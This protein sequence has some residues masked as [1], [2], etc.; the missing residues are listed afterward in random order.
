MPSH[1]CSGR[2][3]YT[4]QGG[5]TIGKSIGFNE[6]GAYL[7]Y[8]HAFGGLLLSGQCVEPTTLV[9][10]ER[11]VVLPKRGITLGKTNLCYE[12]LVYLYM[13]SYGQKTRVRDQWATIQSWKRHPGWSTADAVRHLGIARPKLLTWKRKY[14]DML[15][16]PEEDGQRYRV[17]GAGRPYKLASY[18]F[19]ALEYYDRSLREDEVV[20]YADFLRYLRTIPE[21]AIIHKET[22][23]SR[24]RR[25]M[26]RYDPGSEEAGATRAAVNAGD[27][28]LHVE[29]ELML[30]ARSAVFFAISYAYIRHSGRE[31]S[32]PDTIGDFDWSGYKYVL[33]PVAF[34]DHWSVVFIQNGSDAKKIYYH[35]DSLHNGHDKEYIFACLDWW[36]AVLHT[37]RGRFEAARGFSHTCKPRQ[38]NAVDC[39]I[40]MLH[41]LY[42]VAQHIKQHKPSS[43]LLQI[44]T[45]AKGGFNASK[46]NQART[47]LLS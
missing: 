29:A 39:G 4:A 20:H 45:L 17:K 37:S 33:L 43:I 13:L 2:S 1:V 26:K 41:Y 23:R 28:A 6:S 21:F 5:Y 46:A 11:A 14:W 30:P 18:E 27:P 10:P 31:S 15:E 35:I 12:L 3:N 38:T 36:F 9:C 24:A 34:S 7:R 8:P 25:F 47:S 42:K 22:Q 19:Q 32:A 44:E 40:Y 16:P